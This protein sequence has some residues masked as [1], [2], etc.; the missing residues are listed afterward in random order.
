V[1]EVAAAAR[2]QP[3]PVQDRHARQNRDPD[4]KEPDVHDQPEATEEEQEQAQ[5]GRQAEE[6]AMRY[7]DHDHG[8]ELPGDDPPDE[9]IHES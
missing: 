9:P 8:Q 4:R 7:P 6:E 1:P 5:G 2:A 3:P